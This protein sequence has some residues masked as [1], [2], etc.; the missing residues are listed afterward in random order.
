MSLCSLNLSNSKCQNGSIRCPHRRH[1]INS[2]NV[3]RNTTACVGTQYYPPTFWN[4]LVSSDADIWPAAADIIYIIILYRMSVKKPCP[5]IRGKGRRV[6]CRPLAGRIVGARWVARRRVAGT[7]SSLRQLRR[8]S[9][10]HTSRRAARTHT[11][12]HLISPNR[13]RNLRTPTTTRSRY[14]IIHTRRHHVRSLYIY[15]I[16]VHISH[17]YVTYARVM[18]RPGGQ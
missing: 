1:R 18:C 5:L 8:A 2:K 13:S 14:I 11:H 15:I 10:A 4:R 9:D 3:I 17:I 6:A 12:T 16:Y 7:R